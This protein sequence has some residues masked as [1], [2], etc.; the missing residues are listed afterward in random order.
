MVIHYYATL[1]DFTKVKKV[2]MKRIAILVFTLTTL[3]SMAVAQNT[4]LLQA[5]RDFYKQHNQR[6]SEIHQDILARG[7][8]PASKSSK[9]QTASTLPTNRWF[10]G[11]WEEVKAICVTWPYYTYPENHVGEDIWTAE[12][13]VSGYGP[14]YQYNFTTNGWQ[15]AG[16]GRVVKVVDT[17]SSDVNFIQVFAHVVDAIQQGGAEA[18]IRISYAKDSNIIKRYLTRNSL[19]TS[20]IRWIITTSNSFWYRDCGPICFYYG[21]QDSIGML[22][23]TY[24]PNRALDDSLPYAI[25]TQMGIPNWETSIEWEGGNCLVDGAGSVVS[26]DAIYSSNMDTQGRITWD[27]VNINSI[28]YSYKPALTKA[29]IKDS[30][31]Y[32]LGPRA[33]HILPELKYDG[34]TG[35]VDL[36]A[37]MWDENEFVFSRFPSIY[38]SWTD[39]GITARNIDSLCSYA[40]VF[41]NFY[42]HTNIPFPC[43]DNGG[44]FTSQSSYNQNYT[45]SYSNHTFVN[46]LIIQPCFSNVVNGEPSAAWDK[47]RIDSLKLRYPGYT[48]YPINVSSFDG[49]GGAIH[50]I[51]KQIPADNPVR[52]LHPSHTGNTGWSFGSWADVPIDVTA[53]N[54]SG[55]ASVKCYY[56]LNRSGEWH[57]I[58]LDNMNE[59]NEY[60]NKYHGIIPGSILAPLDT[61]SE[62][63]LHSTTV[64]Y[65]ISVTSNNGKTITKP[66]TADQGGYYT[67]YVGDDNPNNVA[68]HATSEEGFG[69]FFPNPAGQQATIVLNL[70]GNYDIVVLDLM[71]RRMYS[72]Q[73]NGINGSYTLNTA[74]LANGV[75]TVIFSNADRRVVRRLVKE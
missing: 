16:S 12:E 11:E 70:E 62:N 48:I 31:A 24:Y 64:E 63:G 74:D 75:Y 5:R 21:D 4:D 54:K 40:S 20:N 8:A 42:K 61:V 69:H 10:P 26:S 37:D 57:E 45:R 67:F 60:G 46:K 33:T 32:L 19:N 51:T 23:F 73:L 50:C 66:M 27:G 47:A 43:T 7:L 3:M 58:V 34:G 41:G 14:W 56:R 6:I 30:L 36:Y 13:V 52:I 38:S 35:H 28:Q 25:E 55:I 53:R 71:G 72:D 49:L 44:T 22:D 18:W 29:N 9:A 17:A 1:L 2:L 39:F 15:E 68:I 65:Y 59:H